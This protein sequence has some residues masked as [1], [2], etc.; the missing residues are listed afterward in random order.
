MFV[1]LRSQMFLK[2][3]WKQVGNLTHIVNGI[4]GI[5]EEL[6]NSITGAGITPDAEYAEPKISATQDADD[7]LGVLAKDGTYE[8]GE[9]QQYSVP[10]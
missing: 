9:P 8:L 2:I 10:R 6:I 1:L 4:G 3:E 7:A 5:V